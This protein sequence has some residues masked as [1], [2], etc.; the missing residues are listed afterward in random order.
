MQR[1][2]SLCSAW[3]VVEKIK[4]LCKAAGSLKFHWRSGSFIKSERHFHLKEMSFRKELRA[5]LKVFLSEKEVFSFLPTGFGRNLSDWFALNVFQRVQSYFEFYY[6]E[7]AS[8][9]R[10]FSMDSLLDESHESDLGNVPTSLSGK[11]AP[12]SEDR[13]P[14]AR[15]DDSS[16]T[17]QCALPSSLLSSLF[18]LKQ[19]NKKQGELHRFFW[20]EASRLGCLTFTKSCKH[21]ETFCQLILLN[22]SK[23]SRCF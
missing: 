7:W 22:T 20:Y 14:Y 11:S 2:Y 17:H 19:N 5:E 21:T 18:S 12:L 13:W 6:F 16:D 15:E 3:M 9:F 23:S 4:K 8:P 1:L 10:M